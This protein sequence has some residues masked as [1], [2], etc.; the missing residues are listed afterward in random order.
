MRAPA[1]GWASVGFEPI[2]SA[3]SA[4]SMSSNEPVAPESPSDLRIANDVGEWQTREQL[5][6]L[7]VPIAAR[8]RRC[9][10]KQ[11]SFV[12]REDA[13]PAIA[14]G[15]CCALMR[16]SSVLI[17][18]IASSHVARR[19][20]PCSRISG[21]VRRSRLRENWCAK[22]PLTHVWPWLAGPSPG[23]IDAMRPLRT[24][25]SRRQPTPQ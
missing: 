12:A 16:V 4:C 24:C 10:A 25:A 6:T 14:S 7:F 1:T 20:P 2:S 5:S 13:R 19:K 8:I 17:V 21:E 3:A 15:P 23:L 18:W 11:S 9:I 22:R